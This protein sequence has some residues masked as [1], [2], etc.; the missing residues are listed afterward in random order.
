[1]SVC[2]TSVCLPS[3]VCFDICQSVS[4]KLGNDQ[5]HYLRPD[6]ADPRSN[7]TLKDAK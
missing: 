4:H 6:R 5:F 1:M 3:A 2:D 7:N